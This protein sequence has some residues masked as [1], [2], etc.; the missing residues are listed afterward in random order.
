[1]SY[2][3]NLINDRPNWL[4]ILT[5]QYA[6]SAV[7]DGDLVSL[8]Y[9]Q[10]E[11]PMHDPLVQECR[12]MVVH[13]PTGTILAHPYNKFWNHGETLASP[14]DWDTARVLE[15]LDGS[16]MILYWHEGRWC[17]A[18]SGHPTAGG[19]YGDMAG[20]F[21]D[22]FWRTWG[23]LG[24]ELPSGA[25]S[26]ACFM[27]EFCANEHRIVCRHDQPRIVLHGARDLVT[28]YEFMPVRLDYV[29]RS[30]N[31]ELV[32][33]FDLGS[34][35]DALRAVETLDPIQTEGFVVVDAAFN[36]VKIKSPRYV[37][38]HHMKGEATL[39]RAI[40]LWQT[41]E[42]DEVLAHFPEFAPKIVPVQQTLHEA[43]RLALKDLRDL[44][45][46]GSRKE[47]AEHVKARPYSAVCFRHFGDR[48]QVT[49]DV[50]VKT[51]RSQSIASLERL[52]DAIG[53]VP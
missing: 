37:A 47:F 17:V 42:T 53:V 49:E 33:C 22:A 19:N 1:V 40:E 48:A 36:R 44:S 10:I 30:L 15:K 8:K 46:I 45:H 4:E 13:V 38:L 7:T 50:I 6:I 52:V 11:S 51:L 20:T 29:A 32:R 3:S 25:W 26:H 14:I 23:S 35:A 2:V 41:G 43:A 31:W 5:E 28:G 24:M 39:R 18:S 12:G 34:A 21:R 16:L 27:F 9:N